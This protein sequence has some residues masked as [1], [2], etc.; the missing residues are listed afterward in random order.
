M[1]ACVSHSLHL[2]Y[3]NI[4]QFSA[5]SGPLHVSGKQEDLNCRFWVR[6]QALFTIIQLN[7]KTFD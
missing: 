3:E 2:H 1:D 7:K 6:E 5:A 4:C